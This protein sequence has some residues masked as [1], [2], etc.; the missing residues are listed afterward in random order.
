MYCRNNIEG[1]KH[2]AKSIF[3]ITTDRKPSH[4]KNIPF[5]DCMDLKE[6]VVNN[7]MHNVTKLLLSR[8]GQFI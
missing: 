3:Y 7:S 4:P 2:K 5:H 8:R 1:H 6:L